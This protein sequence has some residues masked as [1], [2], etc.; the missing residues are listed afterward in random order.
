MTP[1]F[2][3]YL[4]DCIDLLTEAPH[5][6]W[7]RTV[8]LCSA[9]RCWTLAGRGAARNGRPQSQNGPP[10]KGRCWSPTSFAPPSSCRES[11]SDFGESTAQDR[12]A[13]LILLVCRSIPSKEVVLLRLRH[14]VDV[15][16]GKAVIQQHIETGSRTVTITSCASSLFSVLGRLWYET[17]SYFPVRFAALTST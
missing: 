4:F 6:C 16:G 15:R 8:S 9:R 12:S 2:S 5:T 14:V 11:A 3:I 17:F 13:G 10:W 1:M 7:A